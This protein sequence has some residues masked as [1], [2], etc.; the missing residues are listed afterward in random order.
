MIVKTGHE[1]QGGVRTPLSAPKHGPN[2]R[3]IGDEMRHQIRR[4]RTTFVLLRNHNEQAEDLA[5]HT[6]VL[7]MAEGRSQERCQTRLHERENGMR[8]ASS[9]RSTI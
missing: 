5:H 9:S 4:Y 6:G 3:S 2:P 1:P 8:R 7:W